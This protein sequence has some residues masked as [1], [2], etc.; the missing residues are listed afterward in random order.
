MK[1]EGIRD[2]KFVGTGALIDALLKPV[3]RRNFTTRVGCMSVTISI[4]LC[5][6]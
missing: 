6:F 5:T 3:L 1:D 4:V 2:E